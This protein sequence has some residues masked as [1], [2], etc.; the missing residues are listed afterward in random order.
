MLG[1][2]SNKDHKNAV[3]FNAVVIIILYSHFLLRFHAYLGTREVI[4]L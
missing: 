3:N 2:K 4:C 1:E